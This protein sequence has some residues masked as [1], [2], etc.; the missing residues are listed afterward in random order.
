MKNNKT[1]TA[2]AAASLLGCAPAM[3]IDGLSI[4]LGA[5]YSSGKY[6]GS[7]RTDIKSVPVS[8]KYQSGPL[9]LRL[10]TSWISATGPGTVIASGLGGIG[11]HGGETGSGGGGGSAGQFATVCDNRR[12]ASKPEDSP[13]CTTTVTSTGTG[14]A[15]RRT[16]SGFGD[17]IAAAVYKAIDKNGLIV[18]FTGKIKFATASE[19]KGLGS[20]KNDYAVQV[21][22]EQTVG[23]GYLNGGVGYKWLGDPAGV[24]LR[25]VV[26][27]SIGGGFK[28][29]A[30]TTIGLSYDYAQAARSGNKAPQEV[31]L[32]ASQR[33]N[34][35]FKLNGF[36]FKGLSDSSPDWGAGI[37]LGYY[38]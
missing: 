18:D 6:G 29:V 23:K 31:S 19:S 30:D 12:G 2:F 37:G 7:D 10:S 8:A 3:A 33:L 13:A 32:Y 1:L 38:F 11:S 36:L 34:K 21:E 25:N 20:G 27:G 17:V 4:N 28:P 22:A 35:N 9:T 15:P 26:Y 24:N 16:E 14:T 5:D